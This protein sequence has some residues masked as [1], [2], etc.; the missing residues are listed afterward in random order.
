MINAL[1]PSGTLKKNSNYKLLLLASVFFLDFPKLFDIF[2]K[3]IFL[4][5]SLQT[6]SFIQK[7]WT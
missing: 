6:D 7:F 1:K 5:I 3:Q 4:N 2:D